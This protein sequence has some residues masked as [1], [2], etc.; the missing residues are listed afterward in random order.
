L[1]IDALGGD[2]M[3]ITKYGIVKITR[4]KFKGRIGYYDDDEYDRGKEQAIV[5][6]GSALLGASY[7]L[8][9]KSYIVTANLNRPKA[10]G[11]A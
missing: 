8:I 2:Y 9:P 1:F 3:S 11:I 10:D 5:Y 4:G 6:F 7:H